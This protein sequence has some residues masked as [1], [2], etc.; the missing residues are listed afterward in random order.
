MDDAYLEPYRELAKVHGTQ[1]GV[2]WWADEGTQRLRF[3]VFVH[4]YSFDGRRVLDA[5]C[6]RGDF[7]AYLIQ[8]GIAFEHF[9]GIDGLD[10]VIGYAAGRG[11]INS[12]FRVG[13]FIR[14]PE[15][16]T[17]GDP[18]VICI[19][20]AL[21]TLSDAHVEQVLESSW[22]AASDALIFNFLSDRA[23]PEA[24]LQL[25]PVRRLNTMKLIEWAKSK[26]QYVSFRDDYFDHRHDA[27][28]L[29]QRCP[30]NEPEHRQ[31][32]A[33]EGS[34]AGIRHGSDGTA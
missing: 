25:P 19:S 32:P 3:D 12:E 27:T 22:N 2:T 4:M 14:A 8:E 1:F 13:D 6:N 34:G 9:V 26:T 29:L 10:G 31:R 17:L 15:L 30:A 18:Q 24:W 11:L 20:G 21:N 16:L 5:G 23:G 28:I 33:N 7:A